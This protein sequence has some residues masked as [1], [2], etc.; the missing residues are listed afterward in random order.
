MS[1]TRIGELLEAAVP[2]LPEPAERIAEVRARVHRRRLATGGALAGAV[3][4]TVLLALVVPAVLAGTGDAGPDPAGPGPDA[5]QDGA[6]CLQP[7]DA[8]APG[9]P[10]VDPHSG[11]MA[12]EGAVE[13]VLCEF[14]FDLQRP[15]GWVLTTD[16]DMV[17][18][19]LNNLA[20]EP[21]ER[22]DWDNLPDRPVCIDFYDYRSQTWLVLSFPDGSTIP[23][24][25][26]VCNTWTTADFQFWFGD[27][28]ALVLFR[29]LYEARAGELRPPTAGAEIGVAY[30]ENFNLYCGID[31]LTFDGRLWRA[32]EPDLISLP[33][34]TVDNTLVADLTLV[35][36]DT[37]LVTVV[38]IGEAKE[39][40]GPT[41][42]YHPTTD[43]NPPCD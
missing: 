17:V 5:Y 9:P 20:T 19:A 13:V 21:E 36:R 18:E 15:D 11:H 4:A 42:T 41:F 12:L 43:P 1:E 8:P 6:R 7:A 16:V 28:E 27:D 10:P 23:I 34:P 29:S 33:V 40:D 2:P 32:E 14:N 26:Q 30:R 39:V 37:L 24:F 22:T 25:W 3:V 31:F 38:Q 35:D